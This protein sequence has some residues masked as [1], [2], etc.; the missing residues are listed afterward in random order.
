M[1]E[2]VSNPKQSP[3]GGALN[4]R[5]SRIAR[6]QFGMQYES[7]RSAWGTRRGTFGLVAES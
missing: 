5:Y 6:G 2:Y 1:D 3:H 7:T 4:I